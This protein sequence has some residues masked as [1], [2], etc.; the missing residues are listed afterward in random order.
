M[1]DNMAD[2]S[3]QAA[4]SEGAQIFSR[5]SAKL[6]GR[7][8]KWLAAEAGVPSSTLSDMKGGKVPRAQTMIAIARALKVDLEWLLTGELRSGGPGGSLAALD[9]Q[10]VA[11]FNSL[12]MR[13]RDAIF[14]MLSIMT[15]Y[16]VDVT[17]LNRAGATLQA[18]R[19]AFRPET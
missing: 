13:E 9:A 10:L 8:M 16:V 18:P 5:V 3:D 7:P 14:T 17:D 15:G 1:S 2:K 11:M 4:T 6:D 12:G 19:P